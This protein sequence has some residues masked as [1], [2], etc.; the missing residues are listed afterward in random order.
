MDA[1]SGWNVYYDFGVDRAK[2]SNNGRYLGEQLIYRHGV[3][4]AKIT[5]NVVY[6]GG[7][8]YKARRRMRMMHSEIYTFLTAAC[9]VSPTMKVAWH[10]HCE[11]EKIGS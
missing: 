10:V 7:F 11:F 5:K 1:L 3:V 6:E 2:F 9:A 8:D 4:Q